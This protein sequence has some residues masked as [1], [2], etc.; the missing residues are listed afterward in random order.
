MYTYCPNCHNY[1]SITQEHLDVA[2]GKVRCGHCNHI[3]NALDSLYDKLPEDS[4]TTGEIPEDDSTESKDKLIQLQQALSSSNTHTEE[5]AAGENT[6]ESQMSASVDSPLNA[7]KSSGIDIKEKMERIAASLSA[8]TLDLKH[9][10]ESSKSFQEFEPSQLA[11][12]QR[13]GTE[14][15]I[16]TP[17]LI[18]EQ[19]STDSLSVSDES[20][21]FAEGSSLAEG[22]LT[23]EN[24]EIGP[25]DII[26]PEVEQPETRQAI[27]EIDPLHDQDIIEP[28]DTLNDT[29]EVIIPSPLKDFKKSQVDQDDIE[30]LNSLIDAAPTGQSSAAASDNS[31]FDEL[32]ELNR[33]LAGDDSNA[34]DDELSDQQRIPKSKNDD[35]LLAELEQ[36]GSNLNK[37]SS[38]GYQSESSDIQDELATE[39]EPVAE[40]LPDA[41]LIPTPSKNIS[42]DELVPSFLTQKN[43]TTGKPPVVMFAWLAG[44]IALLAILFIQ[45]L[46]FNSIQFAQDPTYR[47]WL[48]KICPITGCSLPLIRKPR[49]IVTVQH[50]VHSHP[51]VKNA[52]QI[53]LTYKNNAPIT[54]AYPRLE[55]IFSNNMGE[56][57]A[58]RQFAADE[59]LPETSTNKTKLNSLLNSGIKSKQKIDVKLEI[60][61]PDPSALLSFQFNYL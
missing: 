1:F 56:V 45:H 28:G 35:D 10:R 40:N 60:V 46:H 7:A 37:D 39:P 33:S 43:R 53:Q 9:A 17:N 8:A 30:I 26:P 22:S 49:S 21:L 52:L 19:K 55:I 15:E 18:T 50:D 32:D 42:E 3:F 24:G 44:T 51:E 47:P 13:P 2:N 25:L 36:M 59:Y 58:R 20:S 4:V 31:L 6:S 48:E 16:I 57:I 11:E 23:E 14:A 34:P 41:D 27:S 5:P 12:E 38:F 54:Q 29:E 61:D